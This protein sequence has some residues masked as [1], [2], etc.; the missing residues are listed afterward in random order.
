MTERVLPQE[1]LSKL[2][3]I[4]LDI[5]GPDYTGST[6]LLYLQSLPATYVG[7]LSRLN[8][9]NQQLLSDLT[10]FDKDRILARGVIPLEAILS[11][12][13]LLHIDHPRIGEVQ[14]FLSVVRDRTSFDAD[15]RSMVVA[16]QPAPD[17]PREHLIE[18]DGEG[19]SDIPELSLD[20][21]DKTVDFVFLKRGFEA[22]QSVAKIL[23]PRIVGGEHI[24]TASGD[25]IMA[26]GTAWLLSSNLIITNHHVVNARRKGEPDAS[27]PDLQAQAQGSVIE[28]D[29]DSKNSRTIVAEVQNLEA[30]NKALDFAVL[31]LKEPMPRT[32]LKARVSGIETSADNPFACNIIQHPNGDPKR[33]AIRNNLLYQV[34]GNYIR[35]LT[36]TDAGSSGSP[37]FDDQWH[38]VGL[39]RAARY[40][41]GHEH[42]MSVVNE[43]VL[44]SAIVENLKAE[45]PSLLDQLQL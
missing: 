38:V 28:F 19:P 10:Q 14:I 13:V 12:V 11:R 25:P 23:V 29:F 2:F 43:G 1:E 9:P 7:N 20:G 26:K 39:H 31:S 36:D 3:Q 5:V 44:W 41:S 42:T 18:V 16:P 17:A 24:G 30:A 45:H 15:F 6:R 40:L 21:R 32:Q 34:S 33:V 35:Y 8:A 4:L 22:G 27:E 37:V